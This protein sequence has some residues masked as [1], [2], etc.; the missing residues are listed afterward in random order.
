VTFIVNS[1]LHSQ[2][3]FR[4]FVHVRCSTYW[5]FEIVAGLQ[6]QCED[7]ISI[8][9]IIITRLLPSSLVIA[10]NY[11]LQYEAL[12]IKY[13]HTWR[14][15]MKSLSYSVKLLLLIAVM[16]VYSAFTL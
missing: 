11:Q 1:S 8:A 15:N 14:Y 2:L 12:G 6:L 16:L 9:I 13:L 7:I 4:N 5:R 3:S 10:L